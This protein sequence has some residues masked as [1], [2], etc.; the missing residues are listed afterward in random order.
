MLPR[1]HR[2]LQDRRS[3]QEH[4]RQRSEGHPQQ[5]QPLRRKAEEARPLSPEQGRPL[6]AVLR[7]RPVPR[8]VGIHADAHLIRRGTR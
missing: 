1:G 3:E 6:E 7:L 8:E 2:R 5:V 4:F